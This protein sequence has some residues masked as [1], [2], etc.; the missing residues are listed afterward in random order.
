MTRTQIL[1]DIFQRNMRAN[2]LDEALESLRRCGLAYCR[3]EIAGG[4]Q[5]ERWFAQK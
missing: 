4:K 5:S 3:K 2:V 1:H